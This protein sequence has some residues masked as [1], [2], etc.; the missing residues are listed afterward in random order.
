VRW[1]SFSPCWDGPRAA[2]DARTG[3]AAFLS[4]GSTGRA[5]SGT[6]ASGCRDRL[7]G[8][9]WLRS[10][11]RAG[12]RLIH[13]PGRSVLRHLLRLAVQPTTHRPALYI[14]HLAASFKRLRHLSVQNNLYFSETAMTPDAFAITSGYLGAALSA[15]MVIPQLTRVLR[16][17]RAKGVS[18]VSWAMIMITCLTW[19]VY[20]IK[21]GVISQIPGNALIC[22]SAVAIVLATP[23][24][25]AVPWRAAALAAAVSAIVVSAVF[26]PPE[27]LGYLGFAIG[28]VSALP[29]TIKS[30]ARLH[31]VSRSAVSIPT[32][33]L[34]AAAQVC[35]LDYGLVRHNAPITAA[36]VVTLIN[37]LVLVAAESYH[38][39]GVCGSKRVTPGSAW[40]HRI[41]RRVPRK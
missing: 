22:P 26:V 35:W 32:W 39:R 28:L 30:V 38:Q 20:G 15:G 3:R 36:A 21:A 8:W 1:W 14:P 7:S 37:A 34:R 18:P 23:A 2:D 24:K 25:L 27:F 33:L 41:I 29:Q 4:T 19:L 11:N 6:I 17:P 31:S 40:V 16:D 9:H 5:G 13:R 10:P 12:T